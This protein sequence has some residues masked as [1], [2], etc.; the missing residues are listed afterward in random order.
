MSCCPFLNAGQADADAAILVNNGPLFRVVELSV[1]CSDQ[2]PSHQPGRFDSAVEVCAEDAKSIA[3][4]PDF[5]P[6]TKATTNPK[7]EEG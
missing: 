3:S 6:A 2:E 4:H 7:P 5:T 1:S